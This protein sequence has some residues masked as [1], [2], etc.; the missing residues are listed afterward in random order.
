MPSSRGIYPQ[1]LNL[2]LPCCRRILNDLS[3]KGIIHL[4]SSS[5]H[6]F[7]K[8]PGSWLKHPARLWKWPRETAAPYLQAL[9]QTAW[10]FF[11]FSLSLFWNNSGKSF[12]HM[13]QECN[14]SWTLI[15]N[16]TKVQW[17]SKSKVE[18]FPSGSVVRNLPAR[19]W[20]T[21]S[22]REDPTCHTVTEPVRHNYW[23]CALEPRRPQARANAPQQEKPLQRESHSLQLE[24]SPCSSQLEKNSLATKTQHSQK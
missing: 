6:F 19:A 13:E 24:R 2:G 11:W 22:I 7:H 14:T 23:A 10:L 8:E 4:L 5:F 16:S 3:H 20:D 17:G 18:G 9:G 1:G 15:W 12:N 21:G